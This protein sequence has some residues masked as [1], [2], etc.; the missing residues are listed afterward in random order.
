MKPFSLP[1]EFKCLVWHSRL[2]LVWSGLPFHPG[3]HHPPPA[4]PIS[5]LGSTC[6]CHA[7][8][9]WTNALSIS[10]RLSPAYTCCRHLLPG[11][12]PDPSTMWLTS[13][14]WMLLW[15][16]SLPRFV[17]VM[18]ST[19]DWSE[20]GRLPAWT[21]HRRHSAC[22]RSNW[23]ISDV[24]W[25][26]SLLSWLGLSDKPNFIPGGVIRKQT[27]TQSAMRLWPMSAKL[28]IWIWLLG[29]KFKLDFL[30]IWYV[31]CKNKYFL[32]I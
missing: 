4:E 26:I 25:R 18:P 14:P 24:A 28:K 31:V 1:T 3:P 29:K 6:I 23:R 13:L 17:C 12:F 21:S 32:E 8:S 27:F 20:W 7:T 19:L 5:C 22:L 15:P 10:A 30:Y 2:K 9:C 11:M 16:R